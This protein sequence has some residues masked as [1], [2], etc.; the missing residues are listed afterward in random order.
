MAFQLPDNTQRLVIVGRTGTG[1]TQAAAWQL[2]MRDIGFFRWIIFDFKGDELL[3]DMGA[4]EIDLGEL[5][6]KPGLYIV[7]PTPD[8]TEGVEDYLWK[9]WAS[10]NIGLFIDEGYMIGN[11]AAFRALLTQGRSKR[12]PMIILSQRPVW[13]SRFVFSEADFYQVFW[14]NDSEDRKAMQRFIPFDMERR[15]Q[16]FHSVYYAVSLDSIDI[17]SPAPDKE[18]ILQQI[19]AKTARTKE[20][21]RLL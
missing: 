6:K 14:L 1:K 5:P 3:N 16:K 9:I 17:L 7:H 15:Q 12:I 13:L 10:G 2:A 11:S 4:T 21:L 8:E 20:R 18:R 19:N